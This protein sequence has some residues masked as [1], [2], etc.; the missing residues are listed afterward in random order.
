MPLVKTNVVRRLVAGIGVAIAAL[1]IVFAGSP[2][3]AVSRGQELTRGEYLNRG[4]YIYRP[5]DVGNGR[6]RLI[7]QNDG[8]LVLYSPGNSVCWTTGTS[9][10]H[11]AVYQQDGN[12]VLYNASGRALWASNTAGRPGSTVDINRRG[13]LWV[14]ETEYTTRDCL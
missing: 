13:H 3:Q 1:S 8:N 14:G 5:F 12:F 4:D 11:H 7:M 6:W 9:T 2:A 10:G